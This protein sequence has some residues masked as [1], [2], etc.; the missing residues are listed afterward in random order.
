MQNQSKPSELKQKGIICLIINKY[1]QLSKQRLEYYQTFFMYNSSNM[2]IL[3]DIA[4][5][6]DFK[7]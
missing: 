3:W 7:N 5:L 4:P 6:L 1:S 2:D